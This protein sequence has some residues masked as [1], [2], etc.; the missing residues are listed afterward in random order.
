MRDGCGVIDKRCLRRR[1]PAGNAKIIVAMTR[2]EEAV[3]FTRACRLIMEAKWFTG[4]KA[5]APQPNPKKERIDNSIRPRGL[6][7][8]QTVAINRA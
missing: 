1:R 6:P 7:T 2:S 8:N 5:P 3:A 4:G